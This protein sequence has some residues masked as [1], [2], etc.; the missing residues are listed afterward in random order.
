MNKIPV[1]ICLVFMFSACKKENK[2]DISSS[3]NS[4]FEKRELIVVMNYKTDIEDEF[5]F[6]LNHIVKDEFQKKNI[7]IIEKVAPTSIVDNIMA[8]FGEDNFSNFLNINFGNSHEN[9]IEVE[10]IIITYGGNEIRMT[11]DDLGDYFRFNDYVRQDSITKNL[12]T[13]TLD[14]KHYPWMYLKR[15]AIN[16]L[17]KE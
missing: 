6:E 2:G 3:E 13:F 10:S 9:E 8:N 14:G 1:I 5:I 16:T 11:S 7:R 17:K 12:I 4:Q 15:K